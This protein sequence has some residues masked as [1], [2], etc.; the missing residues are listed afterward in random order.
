MESVEEM[1][2]CWGSSAD[3]VILHIIDVK[4]CAFFN[5]KE[6]Y[7][8]KELHLGSKIFIDLC[9]RLSPPYRWTFP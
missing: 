6:I 3:I 8:V 7:A 2:M 4:S 9:N 1:Q 5:D